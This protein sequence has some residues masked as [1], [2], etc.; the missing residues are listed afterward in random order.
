MYDYDG[1]LYTGT[2]V[3]NNTLFQY[4]VAQRQ[5]YT[6]NTALGNDAYGITAIS[7]NDATFCIWDSLSIYISDPTDQRISINT[8]ASGIAVSATYDYDSSTFDGVLLLNDTIF[9]HSIVGRYGYTGG[10]ASGGVYGISS[11]STNDATYCIFD[12]LLVTIGADDVTPYN[13]QQVNFT[14]TVVFAYDSTQ[15]TTYQVSTGR[16]GTHWRSFTDANKSLF[17]DTNAD[18]MYQY[19]ITSIDI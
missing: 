10:S 18:N 12:R 8:N 2:L 15:C 19:A 9:D 13:N 7:S 6:V 16:S 4:S 14:L 3:L 5:D 17:V 1:S 11:I